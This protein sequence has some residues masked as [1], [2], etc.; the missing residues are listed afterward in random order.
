MQPTFGIE[1]EFVLLD[2]A[3]LTATDRAPEAIEALHAHGGGAV[4]KEF[5]PSQLEFG[6]PVLSSAAEGLDA[7]LG[8]R[9]RLRSWADAAGLVAAGAG[10]PFRT[11][12]RAGISADA[13]YAHIAGDIAGVTPDHQI[14]GLHVHVG[15]PDR[16][17]GIRAS[18][19][20]RDWLPTLLAVSVDSPF[21]HG[22][23]TGFDS[24]RS[25]HGRRWTT[26]GVPPRFADAD[27]HDR[28][29]AALSGVGATSDPGTIN[30]NVRLSARYPT[31]EVRV[32][33][34]QLDGRSSVALA[35][36][37]RAIVAAAEEA[38]TGGE[39]DI[40]IT[41]A[42]LWHA[43]RYGV[44]ETLV[45]PLSSRLVPAREA[46]DA[47]RSFTRPHLADGTERE[48]VDELLERLLRDGSSAERQ[49][50]VGAAG[51]DGLAEL[52]RRELVAGLRPERRR[53]TR[54][55]FAP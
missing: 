6:S 5:F 16:E 8:F 25:I 12:P 52:Y 45:H 35:L 50:T 11:Q 15:I 49:R 55:V 43:A 46:L 17:Y 7:V 39:G 42:A 51:V 31:V 19:L 53:M 14:N 22:V 48:L 37:T 29:R 54:R 13:R 40:D 24:W 2:P 34:A 4:G 10:T 26:Y 32:F 44:R 9:A 3:T 36:L 41:D 1:E 28:V 47:L 20:L 18:N 38:P 27:E 30:W 21:W 33:D 23:D